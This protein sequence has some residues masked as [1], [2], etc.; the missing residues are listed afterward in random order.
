VPARVSR[1]LRLGL[2]VLV[3]VVLLRFF[4][5]LLLHLLFLLLLLLLHLLLLLFRSLSV[6]AA[7]VIAALG[8]AAPPAAHGARVHRDGQRWWSE[9]DQLPAQQLRHPELTRSARSR[10]RQRVAIAV[11]P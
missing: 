10:S 9:Q 6:T 1:S 11:R 4:L 5:L 2:L 8:V 3:L 7:L